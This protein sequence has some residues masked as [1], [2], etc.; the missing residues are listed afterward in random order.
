MVP[1]LPIVFGIS[2]MVAVTALTV[3][4]R[5][6]RNTFINQGYEKASGEFNKKFHSVYEKFMTKE[7]NWEKNKKEYDELIKAYEE[8]IDILKK[9]ADDLKRN[10]T[11][12]ASSVAIAKL[13]TTPALYIKGLEK[14]ISNFETCLT[15][16]KMLEKWQ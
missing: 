2:A 13:G 14:E 9:N 8:Y 15:N 16:L 12:A 10:G 3:F 4:F 6:L 11:K 7:K 5:G 1:V